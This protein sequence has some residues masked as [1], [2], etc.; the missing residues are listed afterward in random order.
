M[1]GRRKKLKKKS[2]PEKARAITESIHTS[3]VSRTG[4]LLSVPAVLPVPLRNGNIAAVPFINPIGLWAF[5][6]G[7][8]AIPKKYEMLSKEIRKTPEL[9]DALK[10][11]RFVLANRHGDIIGTNRRKVLGIFGRKRM[12]MADIKALKTEKFPKNLSEKEIKEIKKKEEQNLKT[13]EMHEL[14]AQNIRNARTV[15]TTGLLNTVLELNPIAF[16][17]FIRGEMAVRKKYRQLAEELKKT[18][19]MD[20]IDLLRDYKYVLVDAKGNLAGTNRPR[21]LIGRKRIKTKKIKAARE[22]AE[23]ET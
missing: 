17:S 22:K 7:A 3:R 19:N 5:V 14:L 11:Y 10:D 21:L 13:P 1:F 16:W 9:Y 6:N 20:A 23:L 18:K 4:G 8:D 15:R 12:K 2:L